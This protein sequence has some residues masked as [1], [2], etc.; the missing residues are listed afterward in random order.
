MSVISV[1][2]RI[3]IAAAIAI[4]FAGAI[5]ARTWLGEHDA[6]LKAEAAVTAAEKSFDQAAATMKQ[7]QDAD[8]ARDAQTAQT[9][10][11]L[12]GAAAA[13]KTPQQIS[14]WLPGQLGPLP[15]PVTSS[16]APAT[17][18]NPAPPA[19]FTVPQADLPAL[20]DNVAKCQADA[21]AL[22]AAQQD[23]SSCHQQLQ[24]AGAQLSAAE[25]ERDAYKRELAGGTFWHRV[26]SGAI[27]VGIGA[28]IGYLAGRAAK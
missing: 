24:A 1:R 3:E 15:A 6:R 20:R 4:L 16:I 8:E 19:V 9:I 2:A 7:L 21:V 17:P 25:A 12:A 28:A 14:A 18:Q 23:V 13:Q 26:K 27:K 22:P 11:K 5:G 10:A